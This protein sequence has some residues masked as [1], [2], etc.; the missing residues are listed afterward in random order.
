MFL[1]KVDVS[2]NIQLLHV[3]VKD[4]FSWKR[5]MEH[6]LR[7]HLSSL[8][9]P[10]TKTHKSSHTELYILYKNTPIYVSSRIVYSHILYIVTV[11][12]MSVGT[13]TTANSA[14]AESSYVMRVR[15]KSPSISLVYPLRGIAG[16]L[17]TM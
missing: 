16:A 6:I 12:G 17:V 7:N 11:I 13:D 4:G 5:C 8:T 2:N 1:T 15:F 10:H 14:N 3:H 9:H